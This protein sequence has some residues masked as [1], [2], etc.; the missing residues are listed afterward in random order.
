MVDYRMR[1]IV[2][3]DGPM[4]CNFTIQRTFHT[5]R[6]LLRLEI[7]MNKQREIIAV[8]ISK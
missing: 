1:L 3:E 2:L 8:E 5:I 7:R 4:A 6:K